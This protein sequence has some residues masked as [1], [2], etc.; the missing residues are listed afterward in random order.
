MDRISPG[1]SVKDNPMNHTPT[2]VV[3]GF[4][5]SAALLLCALAALL[6]LAIVVVGL[7]HFLPSKAPTRPRLLPSLNQPQTPTPERTPRPVG[8][9]VELGP[10]NTDAT[11]ELKAACRNFFRGRSGSRTHNA[12]AHFA[13][14]SQS[15][16]YSTW[17]D[18]PA[19]YQQLSYSAPPCA[20]CNR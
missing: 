17:Y 10:L 7:V 5:I 19:Y 14:R 4:S 15:A 8:D 3:L 1:Q 9:A 6:A 2:K 12:P 13:S 18:S 20:A 16:A 11:N